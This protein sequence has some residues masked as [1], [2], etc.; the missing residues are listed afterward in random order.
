MRQMQSVFFACLMFGALSFP[1]RGTA[2]CLSTTSKRQRLRRSFPWLVGPTNSGIFLGNRLTWLLNELR[3]TETTT[4]TEVNANFDSGWLSQISVQA[5]IDFIASV[6]ASYPN[7]VVTDLIGWS[8]IRV[9]AV[10]DSLGSPPPSGFLTFGTRYGASGKIVLFGV[11]GF[12]GSV[13]YPVDQGLSLVQ[14]AD[15]FATLSNASALL[16]GRIEADGQCSVVEAR[17]ATTPRATASIF[18]TWVLA[19]LGEAVALGDIDSRA[20]QA[21]LASEIAPG[22]LINVEPLGTNFPIRDLAILMMGNSDNTAT[23]HLH[24]LVGRSAL[25]TMVVSSGHAS[26]SGLQPFLNIS[27]QFHLFYSFPYV[28]SVAYNNGNYAYRSNFLQNSIV[29]LG[30]LGTGPYFHAD[31]LT[32]ASWKASPTDICRAFS[33]LRALP[34]GSEALSVVDAAL[35]AGRAAR[36][37]ETSIG[38]GTRGSLASGA[39]GLHVLTHAWMLEDAGDRPYVVVAMSN[40]VGGGIDEYAVQSV[41]GRILQLVSECPE[42]AVS[43][44]STSGLG[45]SELNHCLVCASWLDC[46]VCSLPLCSA[47]RSA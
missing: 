4:A 14:A 36:C 26:P 32:E 19:G 39:N 24:E 34:Q 9:S 44:Q 7:A 20:D 29:P 3:S 43:S 2:P 42:G 40:S 25:E 13:Q 47:I 22:G 15:K 18:K 8:P 12:G 35:G 17:N 38:S 41:A 5:T 30:P 21:L 10:I 11:S 28:D 16:V 27:E 6:R 37:A 33:W 45:E 31:L 46:P 23:D 1:A